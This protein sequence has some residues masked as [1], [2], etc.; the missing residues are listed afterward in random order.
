M[1]LLQCPPE[2]YLDDLVFFLT[3]GEFAP[4]SSAD[5]IDELT[6]KRRDYFIKKLGDLYQKQKEDM[7]QAK[8]RQKSR[9]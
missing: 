9:R 2:A 1:S 5:E 4:F 3:V 8:A 6:P 7:E